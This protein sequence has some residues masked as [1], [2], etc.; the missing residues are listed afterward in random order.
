ML[1]KQIAGELLNYLAKRPFLEVAH[2]IE[3]IQ[4]SFEKPANCDGDGIP[5][6]DGTGKK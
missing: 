5:K 3:A 1:D 4:K 2:F 6:K